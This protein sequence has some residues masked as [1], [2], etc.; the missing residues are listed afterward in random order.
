LAVVGTTFLLLAQQYAWINSLQNFCN[1]TLAWLYFSHNWFRGHA[2]P[3]STA[4]WIRDA[5]TVPFIRLM[6]RSDAEQNHAEQTYTVERLIDGVFD[7][8]LCA[9]AQEAREFGSPLLVEYGTEVNGEWFSWNGSW[10]GGGRLGG[11]GDDSLPDGP[12]RFR[13]AYRHIIDLMRSQ[14]AHNILWVFHVDRDDVPDE[15][16]NRLEEYYPGDEWIDWI[17]VSIYGAGEPTDDEWPTFRDMMDEVYPRLAALSSEKPVVLLEFGVTMGHPTGDQA[18]WA[19]A[20]LTDLIGPRWPRVIGF[21]WWNEGWENDNNP[22][23]DTDMRVQSNPA[24]AAVF[25]RLVSAN[26]Q[27]LGYPLFDTKIIKAPVEQP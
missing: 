2:F 4:E 1:R 20:A 16:W 23:H 14:G 11:Y 19:D 24:L 12:E 25:Q 5:G 15:S 9:W 22:A 26:D 7:S 13:D 10:N 21:S 27:V 18:A 6:L 17:G 3:R 8:D